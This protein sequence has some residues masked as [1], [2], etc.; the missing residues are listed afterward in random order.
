MHAEEHRISTALFFSY[1]KIFIATCLEHFMDF[2]KALNARKCTRRFSTKKV[3]FDNVAAVCDAARSAPMAGNICTL[4]LVLVS[5]KKTRHELSEAALEQSFIGDAEYVIVVCSDPGQCV[6]SYG[7]KAE[8]FVR[9][10]AGA[11]IENMFLKA[12]DLG[13]ATCW[14]GAF[15]ENAVRDVL[16]IPDNIQ[17]EAMLPLSYAL[18]SKGK[19]EMRKK[20][21]LK[22]ILNFEK[23]GQ[24]TAKKLRTV[25]P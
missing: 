7:P 19:V 1:K 6:R 11:A 13:L 21:D 8:V 23:W 17:I 16:S 12:V 9:Q 5:D 24:K 10:Q 15:D 22:M 14:I 18:E 2:D 3:S 20:P 4:K 25:V